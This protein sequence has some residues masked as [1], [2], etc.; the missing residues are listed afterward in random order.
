MSKVKS[1]MDAHEALNGDLDNTC[2]FLY[3][4]K[5]L[6]F[7][8][9][10]G[11]ICFEHKCK[12]EL[13]TYICTVDEFNEYVKADKKLL[14]KRTE[15]KIS[16]YVCNIGAY[17]MQQYCG[18]CGHELLS[19]LIPPK[20][21][22][23]FTKAMQDAGELPCIGME[24]SFDRMIV[25]IVGFTLKGMPVF[26]MPNGTVDYFNSNNSYRPIDTRTDK[27]K[28]IDDL[29]ESYRVGVSDSAAKDACSIMMKAIQS[30]KIH[31]VK[32]VGK[33]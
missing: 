33:Q 9:V 12:G 30:G 20:P 32:W 23:I 21:Q 4:D 3:R 10:D 16:C 8:S 11:Y 25:T 26:E 31:G 7:H 29:I 19:E 28:A 5:F 1:V 18:N 27:E 22:P 2:L 14:K 13:L 24:V 17:P 15:D 6:Y